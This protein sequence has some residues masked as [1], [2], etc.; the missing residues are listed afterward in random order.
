MKN[1][2]V[3][4]SIIGS[5]FVMSFQSPS[6]FG[7]TRFLALSR[8]TFN[9]SCKTALLEEKEEFM[10]AKSKLRRKNPPK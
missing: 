10:T 9:Y 3:P 2:V 8:S 6:G 1:S 4:I 5:P 7:L